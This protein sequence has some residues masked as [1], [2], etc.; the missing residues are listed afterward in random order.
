MRL[1]LPIRRVVLF[2]VLLLAALIATLPMRVV[3]GALNTGLAAREVRG[4]VWRGAL[5]ET[6]AGAVVLGDLR[7]RLAPLPLLVARARVELSRGG[8][9]ASR[10]HAAL[11]S[12]GATRVVEQL[13]GTVPAAGL[14]GPI[15]IASLT[16]VDV[17]ARFRDGRC[18]G[19]AGQVRAS[20]SG[21]VGDVALPQGLAGTIRCDRGALLVPLTSS[22][23]TEGV[24]ISISGNGRWTA[25]PRLGPGS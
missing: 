5:L 16:F 1:R 23:G 11:S 20:L 25:T 9:E 19:A 17:S 22:A 12:G 15:P 21:A 4:S 14:P 8:N 18:D 7:A 13:N 2:G 6:R 3:L 24:T 10:F